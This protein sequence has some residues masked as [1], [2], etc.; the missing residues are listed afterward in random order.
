[1]ALLRQRYDLDAT[2]GE[3]R[4]PMVRIIRQADAVWQAKAQYEAIVYRSG[5]RPNG[6]H[7]GAGGI[8]LA[9]KRHVAIIDIDL[10]HLGKG[11]VSEGN[12]VDSKLESSGQPHIDQVEGIWIRPRPAKE[13]VERCSSGAY[14][15]S[16]A[17]KRSTV[18]RRGLSTRIG[19]VF[20]R[21]FARRF[22]R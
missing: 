21:P 4:P 8:A 13:T 18:S 16:P 17:A 3:S 2:Q 9:H 15:S 7:V 12:H 22:L 11:I 6:E 10:E 14:Q 19:G 20:S 5:N 1:M